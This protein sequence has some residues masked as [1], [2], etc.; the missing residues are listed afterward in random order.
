M[1]ASMNGVINLSVRDGWW[2][3]AYNGKNGWAIGELQGGRPEEEDRKDAESLYNI[4]EN[5]IVPLYYDRDRK[6]IPRRWIQIV[7]EAVKT[8]A[9]A[10]NA[11][12]MMVEYNQQMYLPAAG[13][14]ASNN[15]PVEGNKIGEA[16]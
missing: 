10:F 11:C 14:Q 15:N 13:Q 2:D 6:G 12:R 16:K 5:E 4:L 1:K 3:E 9:P 7:K 8:I